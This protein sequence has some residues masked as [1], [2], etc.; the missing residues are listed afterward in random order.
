[1]SRFGPESINNNTEY[2]LH[3]YS[4]EKGGL[5]AL[6]THLSKCQTNFVCNA[7]HKWCTVWGSEQI[8]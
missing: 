6:V 5:G 2:Y 1:M 3:E 4:A 7:Q 8:Y